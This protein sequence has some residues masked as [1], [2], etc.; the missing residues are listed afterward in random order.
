[1]SMTRTATTT[2]V[3]QS[4][5]SCDGAEGLPIIQTAQIVDFTLRTVIGLNCLGGN[6]LDIDL[7][8]GHVLSC[9]VKQAVGPTD[10]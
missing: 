1:M 9:S 4:V 5:C 3:A 10:I 2:D 7:G 8:N 6:V